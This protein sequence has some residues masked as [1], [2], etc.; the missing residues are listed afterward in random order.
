LNAW[1]RLSVRSEHLICW[2]SSYQA[3]KKPPRRASWRKSN[4]SNVARLR[5]DRDCLRAERD[6]YQSELVRLRETFAADLQNRLEASG[7]DVRSQVEREVGALV[8]RWKWLLALLV[9]AAGLGGYASIPGWI[10]AKVE[11]A[12][13]TR[14]KEK[15][16]AAV[17]EQ[18]AAIDKRC[19][20]LLR[21]WMSHYKLPK[22]RW[23]ACGAKYM[24]QRVDF[25]ENPQRR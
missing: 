18:Q 25:D 11:T 24:M 19:N 20:T 5:V 1:L 22:M 3:T 21:N 4:R 16:N 9:T 6:F 2:P 23:I 8:S 17:N 12:V 14:V 10:D 13:D 7:R 15:V